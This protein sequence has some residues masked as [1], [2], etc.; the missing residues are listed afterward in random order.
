MLEM[1]EK[2]SLIAFVFLMACNTS[3]KDDP[4]E[5]SM[6]KNLKAGDYLFV[7][8]K[9]T[10]N[11]LPNAIFF[12]TTLT[13][14]QIMQ[15]VDEY[16]KTVVNNVPPHPCGEYVLRAIVGIKYGVPKNK[17]SLLFKRT[18]CE[19]IKKFEEIQKT[20]LKNDSPYGSWYYEFWPVGEKYYIIHGTQIINNISEVKYYYQ[21]KE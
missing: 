4:P 21:R 14:S 8:K 20:T 12:D 3:P 11:Q 6:E 9:D 17:D 10:T 7:C 18:L 2:I 15:E 13:G 19:D 16:S 5:S 1:T